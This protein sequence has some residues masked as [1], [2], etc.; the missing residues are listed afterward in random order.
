M[1]QPLTLPAGR[2]IRLADF[3]PDYHEDLDRAGA[4]AD[5][6]DGGPPRVHAV[7]RNF[8]FASLLP[9]EGWSGEGYELVNEGHVA[10]AEQRELPIADEAPPGA[11]AFA[12]HV[13]PAVRVGRGRLS[14]RVPCFHVGARC[15][16][17]PAFST[18]TGGAGLR[19]RE[20]DRVFGV[21]EEGVVEA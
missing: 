16:V 21:V 8:D 20:G 1:T 12:G 11:Y 10:E 17:L 13:H 14:V 2:D 6:P 5:M 7:A 9:T 3:D 18:F 15:A 4:E 19:R